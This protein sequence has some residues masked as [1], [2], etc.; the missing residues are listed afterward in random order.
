[1]VIYMIAVENWILRIHKDGKSVILSDDCALVPW[2]RMMPSNDDVTVT[3][4]GLIIRHKNKEFMCAYDKLKYSKLPATLQGK[5][6]RGSVTVTDKHILHL[7]YEIISEYL[8]YKSPV[9]VKKTTFD[10]SSILSTYQTEF[11]SKLKDIDFNMIVNTIP[12]K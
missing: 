6:D 8:N 4:E 12:S 5:I 1:M 9:M 10:L 3:Q 2:G 7:F 11:G